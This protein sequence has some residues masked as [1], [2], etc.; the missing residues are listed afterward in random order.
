MDPVDREDE[1]DDVHRALMQLPAPAAPHTLLPRVM[2][3]VAGLDVRVRRQTPRTWLTWPI[4]WQAASLAALTLLAIGVARLWPAARSLGDSQLLD[5]VDAAGT[6]AAGVLNGLA[7]VA[8]AAGTVWEVLLQPY[9][10]YVLVWVVV[11]AAAC[12]GFAAAVGR[13]ALQGTSH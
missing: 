2:T 11:M 7:A 8:R 6:K 1:A 13:V 3:A 5:P 10:P 4:E 9:A 12:A